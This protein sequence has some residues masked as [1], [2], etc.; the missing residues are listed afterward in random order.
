VDH[1]ELID[2]IRLP[3]GRR[4]ERT[5][6]AV[7]AE[8]EPDEL[9]A[10]VDYQ[11]RPRVDDWSLR[12]A[13]T[14]YAQPEPQRVGDLLEVVR[15]IEFAMGSY[16]KT[17]ESDGP[18]L[19]KSLHDGDAPATNDRLLGMLGA[20]VELDDLGERLATW[21][22]DPTTE[23]PDD[24]VDATVAAVRRRLDELGIPSEERQPTTARR[25]SRG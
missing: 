22:A 20:M 3:L 15:R 19:W 5:L 4:R 25:R 14:R 6:A 2:R 16:Q 9:A 18:Q 8:I 1:A 21:A 10:L 23:R 17:I 12:A 11:E 7:P 13:L 24:A